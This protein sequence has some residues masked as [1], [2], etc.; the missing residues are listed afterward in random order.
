VKQHVLPCWFP[1]NLVFALCVEDSPQREGQYTR[2]PW[3]TKD[4]VRLS[5]ACG[6]HCNQ[7]AALSAQEV[8][9]QRVHDLREDIML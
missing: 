2:I 9:H 5:R 8:I 4:G 3:V 1:G 7:K 6:A